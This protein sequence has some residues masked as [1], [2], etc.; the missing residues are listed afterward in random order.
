M[1]TSYYC[2]VSLKKY[3]IRNC[4]VSVTLLR[5]ISKVSLKENLCEILFF[6]CSCLKIG[7]SLYRVFIKKFFQQ[8][9]IFKFFFVLLK[10]FEKVFPL[11]FSLYFFR[12]LL[13]LGLLYDSFPCGNGRTVENEKQL[14]KSIGKWGIFGR[15][16]F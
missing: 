16:I 15:G 9:F 3:W 1:K 14:I 11:T 7:F 5:N 10:P 2:L 4:D 8:I 6:L 12:H 13:L